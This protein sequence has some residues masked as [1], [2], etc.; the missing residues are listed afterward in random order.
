M[1][2]VDLRGKVEAVIKEVIDEDAWRRCEVT[3]RQSLHHVLGNWRAA[4][5]GQAT[6]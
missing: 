3:E 5:S 6:T 1:S 4:M 2:P